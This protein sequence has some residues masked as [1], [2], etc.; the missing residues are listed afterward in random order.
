MPLGVCYY[1]EHWPEERWPLDARLMRQ[2][3]LEIVRIGEFAWAK[4]EPAEGRYDWGWLDRAVQTLA[5][6]G[7]Q[8]VLGTPTPTPPAWLVRTHP[9]V[10]PVGRDGQVRQFGSRRHYCHNSP[11]YRR[12]T[13]QIVS[14]LAERYGA[15]PAV[16]GWQIDNEFG[17]HD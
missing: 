11:L 6:E 7:L 15:H 3:G 17:C 5:A 4:M 12:Y 8:V 10:L 13:E 2:A 14:A 9:E 16:I 1:P